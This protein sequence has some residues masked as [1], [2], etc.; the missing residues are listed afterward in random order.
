MKKLFLGLFLVYLF[1][2]QV[3]NVFA[4]KDI[5]LIDDSDKLYQKRVMEIGYNILNSNKIAKRIIFGV[6][7][8]RTI[9]NAMARM[10]NHSVT[11]Y[12]GMFR[13]IENDDE[14]AFILAHE[15]AHNLDFYNG[16]WQRMGMQYH[17]R[18][19]ERKADLTALDL[20]SNAGYN[21]LGS[22]TI[23]HK[24]F[25][26]SL[27]FEVFCSHPQSSKRIAM[28]Y[29]HIKH[30]YPKYL[31]SKEYQ[32]NIYYQNFLMSSQKAIEEANNKYCQ[33]KQKEERFIEVK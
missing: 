32:D 22:I 15:I 5:L 6:E 28:L 11:I 18:Y 13:Y 19:Y 29:V 9:V 3:Q 8:N 25:G 27:L 20:M 31:H 14:L 30:K 10:D 7:S 24:V 26:E 1:I 17:P 2:F 23:G 33:M 16:F 12:K 21:P 4:A